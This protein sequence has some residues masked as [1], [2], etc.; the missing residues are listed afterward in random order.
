VGGVGSTRSS[1][2]FDVA[3]SFY[4]QLRQEKLVAQRQG[5]VELS[6]QQLEQ[7]QAQV[8]AGAAARVDVQSVQVNL[9]QAR[10]DLSTAQNNL[11]TAQ[12]NFRN[13]LGLERGPAIQLQ[14]SVLS[15]E[16]APVVVPTDN[17]S[18]AQLRTKPQW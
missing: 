6:R 3:S 1:L 5:Q 2:A 9:S 18:T 16:T 13:A 10:F 14:E 8:E 17:S 11:R 15:A 12:T 4:E 7:I